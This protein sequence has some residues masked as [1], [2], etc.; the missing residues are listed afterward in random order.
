MLFEACF[1]ETED[2][3]A[4]LCVSVEIR[5]VTHLMR[6]LIMTHL[7]AELSEITIAVFFAPFA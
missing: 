3:P 5:S 7:M 2:V 1:G 4:S 6:Q